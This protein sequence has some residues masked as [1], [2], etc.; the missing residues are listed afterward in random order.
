MSAGKL[1]RGN[2]L[3][4]LNKHAALF[5]RLQC[6]GC[7]VKNIAV[8]RPQLLKILQSVLGNLMYKARIFGERLQNDV[9]PLNLYELKT[10]LV[11]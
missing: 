3:N 10:F 4:V 1:I 8:C 9:F 7:N 2:I 6:A 5:K 11:S